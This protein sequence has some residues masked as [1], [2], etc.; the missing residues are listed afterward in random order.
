MHQDEIPFYL[1]TYTKGS[2]QGIY[3]GKINSTTG[4]LLPLQLAAKISNPSFLT[5]SPDRKILYAAL[6]E[7]PGAVAAFK[8]NPDGSLNLLNQK[9]SGG[10]ASCHVF[11]DK[12]GR[13]IFVS[14]YS[15]GNVAC[16]QTHPDGSIGERTALIP[17]QDPV[18]RRNKSSNAHSSY[19]DASN[20]FVY[21]CDLGTDQIWGFDFDPDEG[22]VTPLTPPSAG[23]PDGSGPRHLVLPPHG[24]VIYANNEYGKSVTVFSRNVDSGALAELQNISTLPEGAS[25]EKSSTAESALHPSGKWL[26]VSNRGHHSLTSFAVGEKGK[27]SFLENV[28]AEVQEPRGFGLD[29]SGNWLVTAGQNDNRLAVFKLD[30]KTGRLN[31][32]GH[33]QEAPSPVCVLF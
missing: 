26:Y 12:T 7:E 2:S 32:T 13:N 3:L 16:F 9:P 20:R 19:T 8:V 6:E 18:P 33:S 11:L 14:H 10:N 4:S 21:C 15:S 30:P 27:L 17:F 24:K 22:R 28:S 25:R 23:T 29:P 31:F 5:F 1:G